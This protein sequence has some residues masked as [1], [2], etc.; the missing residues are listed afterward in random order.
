MQLST[1]NANAK[2]L[3][4]PSRVSCHL[5]MS[6]SHLYARLSQR[7]GRSQSTRFAPR[8]EVASTIIQLKTPTMLAPPAICLTLARSVSRFEA[9]SNKLPIPT[10]LALSVTYLD[11]GRAYA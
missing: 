6:F 11:L 7:Q 1:T 8:Y 3:D 10:V 9:F 4:I 2:A 5:S